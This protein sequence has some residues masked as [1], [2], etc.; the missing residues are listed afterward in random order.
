MWRLKRVDK[1]V[2][3]VVL[4]AVL[5]T[6][7]LLTG[8]DAFTAFVGEAGDIGNGNYGLADATVRILLTVPRRAY[9]MFSNAALIGALLG[10]GTLAGSGEITALRAAG[11]SKLRICSSVVV[12]LATLTLA[13]TVI[14]ETAGP[15]GEQKAQSLSLQAKSKDVALARG[16]GLWARDGEAVIN[17]KRG[18]TQQTPRG[19][20]VRLSDVRVFEFTPTGRLLS[21]ALAKTAE[22]SRGAWVMQDVRRTRFDGAGATSTVEAMAAWTSGLDPRVLALSIVHPEYLSVRDLRRSI[23]YLQRNRQD[24]Q[25]F[26]V[27]FWSRVFYPLNVLALAFCAVP[28]AFGTLRSGG[29]GKRLFL[30]IVLAISWYFLQ[31]VVVNFGAVY[32]MPLALANLLPVF[33][34]AAISVVYFRRRA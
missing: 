24:A 18:T 19:L 3:I 10:L 1:M 6:W 17:A 2:A 25:V 9:E 22:H 16:S 26:E 14:G 13:V 7:V 23:D 20:E 11:L 28:F 29:L 30:G 5:M 12:A 27:A 8:F 34:L 32:G 4:S 21:I 33:L 31:R 15:A